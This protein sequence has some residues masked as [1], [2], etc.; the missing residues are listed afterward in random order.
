MLLDPTRMSIRLCSVCVRALG[1][2][3]LL[4]RS[5]PGRSLS[6]DSGRDSK[7][8][9]TIDTINPRVKEMQ[10]AVRGRI[11][12]EAMSIEAQLKGVSTHNVDYATPT[13]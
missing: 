1:S 11:P 12:L 7:F 2:R 13:K 8:R 4:L 6:S 3:P 5:V 9:L 10:Y